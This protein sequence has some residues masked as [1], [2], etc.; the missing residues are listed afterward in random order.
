MITDL[1]VEDAEATSIGPAAEG[2]ITF[3]WIEWFTKVLG[4]R[5]CMGFIGQRQRLGHMGIRDMV[6]KLLH[7]RTYDRAYGIL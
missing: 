4:K 2:S 5:W 1:A 6:C 7:R 3:D